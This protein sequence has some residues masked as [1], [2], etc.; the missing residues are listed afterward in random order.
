M[1]AGF[2]KL[3]MYVREAMKAKIVDGDL[4][5][6]LSKNRKRLKGL[7][8]DGTGLVQISKMLE[9]GN[10]M[11]ASDLESYQITEEELHSLLHGSIIRRTKFGDEALTWTKDS[12]NFQIEN[13][14]H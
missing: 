4:F 5:T 7:C 11:K 10:F 13:G 14:T 3:S 12:V 1:R 9:N 6:F 8:Y 2:N